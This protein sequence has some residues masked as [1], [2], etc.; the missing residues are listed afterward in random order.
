MTYKYGNNET[1]CTE[2]K[3]KFEKNNNKK[4]FL[5]GLLE[6][7]EKC[8]SFWLADLVDQRVTKINEICRQ[9]CKGLRYLAWKYT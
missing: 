4:Y 3:I 9:K 1:Y 8:R 7:T 5:K 2:C 6:T